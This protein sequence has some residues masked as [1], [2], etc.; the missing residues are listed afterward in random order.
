MT[1]AHHNFGWGIVLADIALVLLTCNGEVRAAAQTL[2]S[3][4]KKELKT[5]LATART[6]ADQQRLAAYYR[7]TAQ[8]LRAKAQE[9]SAQADYL[10]TQPATMESKQ[11]ISCNCTSHCRYFSKLYSQEAKDAE[12]LAANT[13]NSRRRTNRKRHSSKVCRGGARSGGSLTRYDSLA[14]LAGTAIQAMSILGI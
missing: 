6:S 9:F 3:I 7:D 12:T 14:H 10:A 1:K 4:S 5:L 13:T 11:G 8:H 2:A